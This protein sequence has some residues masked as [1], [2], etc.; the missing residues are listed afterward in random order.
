MN[1][2]QEPYEVIP[3]VRIRAGGRSQGRSLPRLTT[4]RSPVSS[5]SGTHPESFRVKLIFRPPVMNLTCSARVYW[6]YT[7]GLWW[8]LA[9]VFDRLLRRPISFGIQC[10]S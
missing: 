9:V 1:P 6:Q 2:R 10:E 3:H 7:D 5:K 4:M 8:I